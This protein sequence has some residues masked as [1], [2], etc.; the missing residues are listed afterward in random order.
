MTH[1]KVITKTA[2]EMAKEHTSLLF[3]LPL[4][5]KQSFVTNLF[6]DLKTDADM[7]E[8]MLEIKNTDKARSSI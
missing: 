5:C 8:S 2:K 3:K 6:L 1:M 7:L 4:F